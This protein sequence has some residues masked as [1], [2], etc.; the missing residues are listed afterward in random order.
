MTRN[1]NQQPWPELP[2]SI[3]EWPTYA[4]EYLICLNRQRRAMG[5][6][7]DHCAM[8]ATRPARLWW[9][10]STAHRWP[11]SGKRAEAKRQG[12]EPALLT[13]RRLEARLRTTERAASIIAPAAASP[14][15]LAEALAALG[16]ESLPILSDAGEVAA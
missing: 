13:L 6:K 5:G 2:E 14:D 16:L 7:P 4:M 9:R 3:V 10:N 15:E 12:I 8:E 1:Q 11:T